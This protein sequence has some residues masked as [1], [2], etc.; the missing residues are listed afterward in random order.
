M[1]RVCI[2]IGSNLGDRLA[3]VR[4]AV[5]SISRLDGVELLD[6]SDPVETEA[7]GG[8]PGQP[9]YINAAV[10][11]ETEL[12]PREL[13]RALGRIEDALGRDRAE[14]WGP[15]TIDL[16]ILLYGDTVVDLDDLTVPHLLMHERSFVLE[17]LAEIA[18]DA[19][20]PILGKTVAEMLEELDHGPEG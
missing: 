7:V 8:P 19:V 3:N 11:V 15:R 10:V 12:P 5:L 20:H 16:D 2:G 1:A 17:P 13:L 6:T 9:D 14:R 18:P 4:T